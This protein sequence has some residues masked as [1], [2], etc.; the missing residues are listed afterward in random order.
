MMRCWK[1]SRNNTRRMSSSLPGC[2]ARSRVASE[3]VS[4]RSKREVG[5]DWTGSS[6]RNAPG[7]VALTP[8]PSGEGAAETWTLKQI[9]HDI[10]LT[11]PAR[12]VLEL[13]QRLATMRGASRTDPVHLLEAMVLL[14]KNAGHRALTALNVNTGALRQWPE[15][16]P[17]LPA[18]PAPISPTTR[19]LLNN[20][21]REAEQ[22]GHYQVDPAHLLLA[23][24]YRDSAQ[25]ADR[26]EAAGLSIYAIRQYLTAPESAPKAA[27][28]PPLPSL[29]GA[30]RVSP[31]FAIPVGAAVIGGVVYLN[32][33]AI[34]SDRWRSFASAAGP[35]GNLL[36]AI[37]I[38]WPFLVFQGQP[39]FGDIHFWAALA[40]LVFLQF[41][42]LVLN[43]IPIPPFDGFGIISPWL[44]VELRVL[45]S[46]LGMLPLLLLFYLLWQGGPV[47][48]TF[49]NFVSSL[50]NLLNVPEYLVYLGQQQF[51][52]L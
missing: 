48:A 38:G 22:M 49:W 52:H 34:R 31:V 35:V 4:A 37:L 50:S 28:R 8:Q 41:T 30:R 20:A 16:D 47:S 3:C 2:S 13:G 39:P 45:A 51:P 19:Y 15:L 9:T 32:E 23:L 46:R 11:G 10:P 36:F 14:P 26:L 27:R 43:L 25:T 33:P 5:A 1:W 17:A 12:E 44:S 6:R 18:A 40:F 29:T 7:I 24:L 21:H 42:A